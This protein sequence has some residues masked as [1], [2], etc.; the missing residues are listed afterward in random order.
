MLRCDQKQFM[1]YLE[2][3]PETYINYPNEI[4]LCESDEN[5]LLLQSPSSI[6]YA[7]MKTGNMEFLA[8]LNLMV[9]RYGFGG[10]TYTN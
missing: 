7:Y 5:E 3:L 10:T 6:A 1:Q 8:N 9:Q 2:A 4:L